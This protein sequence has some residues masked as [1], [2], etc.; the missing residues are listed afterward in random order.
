VTESWNCRHTV[1]DMAARDRRVEFVR[2]VPDGYVS[3]PAAA[4]EATAQALA[5]LGEATTVILVE[6]VS[7]QIAI[8]TLA[9]ATGRDLHAHDAAVVPIGGAQAIDHFVARFGPGGAG[10]RIVALCDAG[11][12]PV[13]RRAVARAGA[14]VAVFVCDADL[15]DELIRAV[16]PARVQDLLAAHGDLGS[17]R[18]LQKQP[19]WRAQPVHAQLRRYFASGATRKLRYA[20]ELAIAAVAL[21]RVPAPLQAVLEAA[22]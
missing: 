17:F 9:R 2:R 4:T 14:D 18:T 20:E 5:Q 7:D 16:T 11:E 12:E 3:G 10:L 19:T 8:E 15:E 6:G 22:T 21:G 1:L 13:V